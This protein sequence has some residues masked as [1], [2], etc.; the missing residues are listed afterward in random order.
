[1]FGYI[2]AYKPELRLKEWEMY[3]AVYCT[4]CKHLGKNY[5]MLSRFTLSYDFTFL[6]LLNMA[7]DDGEITFKRK[8][9]KF[10]PFKKCNYCDNS[11][12]YFFLP[13]AT[14]MIMVYYKILDNI[15]DEKGIKKLCYH[16]I[17]PLFSGAHK[18]AAQKYPEIEEIIKGYITEQARLEKEKC[19]NLDEAAMPTA[20]ALAKL[21]KMCA[22]DDF[23]GRALEHLGYCMGR[24]IYISDALHDYTDDVKK[25]R[26]NPLINSDDYK[27]RAQIQITTCVNESIKAFE[28]LDIKRF[29]NI[30]GNIIYLGLEEANK[31][32]K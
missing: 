18:K 29:K 22:T 32:V 13:S 16:A 26:Y 20:N 14:A 6:C 30:L 21:F 10:N 19:Q 8:C 27:A 9:C 11:D 5:G 7:L 25:G 12:K 17:K 2:K 28:L 3:K 15:A 23:N 31:G 4:L 1:M 24:F